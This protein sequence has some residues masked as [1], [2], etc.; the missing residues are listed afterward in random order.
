MGEKGKNFLLAGTGLRH[1]TPDG[2]WR[3]QPPAIATGLADHEWSLGERL[4]FPAVQR[5]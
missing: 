1:Q 5:E 4:V 3:S 2:Q